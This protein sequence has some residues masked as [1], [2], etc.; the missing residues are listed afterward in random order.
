L[1]GENRG[2]KSSDMN[3]LIP[4]KQLHQLGSAGSDVQIKFPTALDE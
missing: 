3:M 1:F 2:E 4:F